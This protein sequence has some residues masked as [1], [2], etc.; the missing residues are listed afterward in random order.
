MKT[1]KVVFMANYD[2]KIIEDI[3]G[4][5]DIGFNCYYNLKT[6]EIVKLPNFDDSF[7]E[8]FMR[9]EFKADIEKVEGNEDDYIIFEILDS[10]EAFKIMERFVGQMTDPHFQDKL[11]YILQREKP[12]RYFKQAIDESEHRQAWFDFKR[13]ELERRVEDQFKRSF[14][15]L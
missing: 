14:D 12:F 10:F 8:D 3:A 5:L 9:E 7:D 2:R 6:R 1:H 11:D 4:D 15:P 13:N